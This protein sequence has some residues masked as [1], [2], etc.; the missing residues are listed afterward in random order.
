MIGE[1]QE[2]LK[3]CEEDSFKFSIGYYMAKACRLTLLAHAV[4]YCKDTF[5]NN[6]GDKIENQILLVSKDRSDA[7]SQ[8]ALGCGGAGP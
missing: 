3:L 8:V 6:S 2:A 7:S 4:G 1:W 5:S